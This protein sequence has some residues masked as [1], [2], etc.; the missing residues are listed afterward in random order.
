MAGLGF[1]RFQGYRQHA[2][3]FHRN[4]DLRALR[5]SLLLSL[6]WSLRSRLWLLR[7]SFLRSILLFTDP[8]EH[9][10]SLQDSY[11]L[12]WKGYVVSIPGAAVARINNFVR[13]PAQNESG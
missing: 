3:S 6:L 12:Q 4:V 2:W 8:A 1:T 10:L 9:P 13:I 7:R 5:I 11:F